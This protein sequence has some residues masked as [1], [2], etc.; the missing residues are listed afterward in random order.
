MFVFSYYYISYTPL[1]LAIVLQDVISIYHS[2]NHQNLWTE[3]IS[4]VLIVILLGFSSIVLKI[5]MGGVK[6]TQEYVLEDV[7]VMKT[8][9][10]DFVLSNILPLLAFDFTIWYDLLI[11]LFFFCILCLLHIKNKSLGVNVVFEILQYNFYQ[12]KLKD[13]DAGIAKIVMSKSNL[14]INKGKS[15]YIKHIT[16]ELAVYVDKNIIMN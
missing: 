16:N 3:W 13:C 15:V 4:I 2:K 8:L 1:W 6:T 9:S 14:N 7:K 5:G 12:C 11:F 10:S